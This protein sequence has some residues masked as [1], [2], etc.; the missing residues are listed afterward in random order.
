MADSEDVV[1]GELQRLDPSGVS[2]F[3]VATRGDIVRLEAW[4]KSKLPDPD[5]SYDDIFPVEHFFAPH[6]YARQMTIPAGSLIIGKI[7]KHAHINTVSKGK[8][9]VFSEFGTKIVEAPCTFISEPGIK[10]VG[11]AME[12]T[13]WTTYHPSEK[14]DPQE[15]EADIVCNTFEE[16]DAFVAEQNLLENKS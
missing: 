16:F 10:R 15:A 5:R 9:K 12:E 1:T 6:L 8:I 4:V 3:A 14:T 7:H 11:V 13:V 2:P